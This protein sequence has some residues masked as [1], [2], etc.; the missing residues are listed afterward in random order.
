MGDEQHADNRFSVRVTPRM[1]QQLDKAAKAVDMTRS[2]WVAYVLEGDV[3]DVA[4]H[5]CSETL[6]VLVQDELRIK[7]DRERGRATR[8]AYVRAAVESKIK[9]LE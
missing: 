8:S 7:I 4:V 3:P 5:V 9:E 1:L 2:A 6:Q